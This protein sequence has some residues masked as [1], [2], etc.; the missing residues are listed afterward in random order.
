MPGSRLQPGE[1]LGRPTQPIAAQHNPLRFVTCSDAAACKIYGALAEER[2]ASGYHTATLPPDLNWPHTLPWLSY[3]PDAAQE[4]LERD[5]VA[6][7]LLFRGGSLGEGRVSQ[8]TF[9]AAV[10]ALA[11]EFLGLEVITDQLQ[12]RV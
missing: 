4:F 12:V 7:E 10:Y 11:G 2:A 9:V 8:L 1:P 5:D 3:P 6:S